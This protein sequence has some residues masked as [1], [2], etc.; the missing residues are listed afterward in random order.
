MFIRGLLADMGSRKSVLEE[1]TG[2]AF[3][4]SYSWIWIG[5][6]GFFVFTQLIQNPPIIKFEP[7]AKQLC[8]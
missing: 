7:H 8:V 4:F 2:R 5:F 3:F 1:H 6:C